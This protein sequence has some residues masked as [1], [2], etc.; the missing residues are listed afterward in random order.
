MLHVLNWLLLQW[1]RH[2]LLHPPTNDEVDEMFEQAATV[3]VLVRVGQGV[4]QFVHQNT[5]KSYHRLNNKKR[6]RKETVASLLHLLWCN[7]NIGTL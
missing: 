7:I 5:A 6:R 4:A 2:I 3:T 1:R